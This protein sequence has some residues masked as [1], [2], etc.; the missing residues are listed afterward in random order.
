MRCRT[1]LFPV[2]VVTVLALGLGVTTRHVGAQTPAAPPPHTPDLLGIYTGMASD[3][4][5]AQLQK[6]APRAGVTINNKSDGFDLVIPDPNNQEVANLFVTAPP[7]DPAVWMVQRSQNFSPQNPMS[8]TALLNA[9][10]EKY[11]KETVTNDR[12]GGGLYLFWIY[13]QTGKLLPSADMDLTGCNPAFYRN[14]VETGP[15]ASLNALE[16]KCFRSFFAVAAILN[17]RDAQLLDSYAVQLVNLPYA[18]KAATATRNANSSAADRARQ[19][20]IDKADKNKP[21]F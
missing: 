4:A 11:G 8:R 2:T 13:D 7:N 3:A 9:L 5:R 17:M 18:L 21:K 6:H 20:Q 12:G 14:Y 19:E 10:H 1:A 16:D 15:P